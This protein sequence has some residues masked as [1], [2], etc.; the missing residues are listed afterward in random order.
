MPE[1]LDSIE[2]PTDEKWSSVT[3]PG[4]DG[5]P[6]QV[7]V[8]DSESVLA[9]KAALLA[10]RPLLVRGEP[11]VG[12]SQLAASV[13]L[14]LKRPFIPFVVDS[15]T[16]SRDLKWHYD[17]V[18]RLAD[19]QLFGALAASAVHSEKVRDDQSSA[20]TTDCADDLVEKK[21]AEKLS[22]QNYVQPGPLWWAFDWDSA[23][24]QAERSNS[25]IRECDEANRRSGA[26]VLIDE[27]DKA[28]SDVPN[29]LLEALGDGQF[30]PPGVE[31]PVCVKGRMPLVL[32]SSNREREL[33]DAFLRQLP[34]AGSGIA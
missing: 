2:F 5:V 8:F 16:E 31:T 30:T 15:R 34:C 32:I 27:I 19:A 12:K 18:K 11:G 6:E 33:P 20:T 25:P 24:T 29:G 3:L 23:K 14:M 9:I 1:Y 21:M 13:A 28:G 17:A 10:R 7:H 22:V 4:R 26:V